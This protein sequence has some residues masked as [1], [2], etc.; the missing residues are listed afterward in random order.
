MNRCHSQ[1]GGGGGYFMNRDGWG[2]VGLRRQGAAG[3]LLARCPD[4]A[5]E[6]LP[7]PYCLAAAA[8]AAAGRILPANFRPGLAPRPDQ[9]D[10][11]SPAGGPH[12]GAGAAGGGEVDTT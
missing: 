6:A 1:V 8:A 2:L 10:P 7:A 5:L 3:W 12:V 9:V 11:A 4:L